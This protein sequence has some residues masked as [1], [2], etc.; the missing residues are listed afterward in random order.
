M[1]KTFQYCRHPTLYCLPAPP[2]SQTTGAWTDPIPPQPEPW[3]RPYNLFPFTAKACWAAK[4][5]T[6]LPDPYILIP[7]GSGSWRLQFPQ[8]KI[9]ILYSCWGLPQTILPERRQPLPCSRLSM[10]LLCK[11]SAPQHLT[12]VVLRDLI[13]Q[14]QQSLCTSSVLAQPLDW[15]VKQSFR[16]LGVSEDT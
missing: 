11:C 9:P 12:R 14:T 8:N 7:K 6:S 5:S 4:L 10:G 15:S 2:Y 16:G 1:S 13:W 3:C